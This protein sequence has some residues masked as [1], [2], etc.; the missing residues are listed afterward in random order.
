M[1]RAPTP[2]GSFHDERFLAISRFP[3]NERKSI[4]PILG[5]GRSIDRKT[6]EQG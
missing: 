2:S 5:L 6:R 3:R 1:E 4:G